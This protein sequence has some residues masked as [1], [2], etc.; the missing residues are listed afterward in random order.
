MVE[1]LKSRHYFRNQFWREREREIC[2]GGGVLR[3]VPHERCERWR[4]RSGPWQQC[5]NCRM[6]GGQV[7]RLLKSN[8][9]KRAIYI[10][11]V[12]GVCVQ[13]LGVR[14]PATVLF[15]FYVNVYAVSLVFP[16]F[17]DTGSLGSPPRRVVP[18]WVTAFRFLGVNKEAELK[19]TIFS[20]LILFLFSSRL[21]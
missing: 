12:E 20:S 10:Y 19:P 1:I 17:D 6:Q 4:R 3:S 5:S 7:S 15:L 14:G 9:K 2:R 8:P 13:L 11:E 16:A 21:P 18:T